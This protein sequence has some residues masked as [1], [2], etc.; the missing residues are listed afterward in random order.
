M[1]EMVTVYC[2]WV[3]SARTPCVIRDAGPMR[4]EHRMGAL[5][6]RCYS[7]HRDDPERLGARRAVP[8]L[9]CGAPPE[10]IGHELGRQERLGWRG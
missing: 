10:A 8:V 6:E 2:P 9:G 7:P 5:G 4:C 3:R 1:S